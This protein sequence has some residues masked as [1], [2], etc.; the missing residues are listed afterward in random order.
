MLT[1]PAALALL[2]RP[3]RPAL[4]EP[5]GG[6]ALALLHQH[7]PEL[8]AGPPVPDA[9]PQR[10]DQHAAR[11]PQLDARARAGT[12]PRSC[13]ATT[14]RRSG[15][16]SGTTSRTPPRSTACSS[17]S[18]SSGRSPA[19]AISML[20]PEAFQ[21]RPELPQEVATSTPTTAA[22]VEP[23]DGPAAVAFSDG[24]VVGATLDRNGLRPGRWL[25][26]H[27]GWVVLASE[28][29]VFKVTRR[30]RERPR[31]ACSRASSSWSTSRRTAIVPDEE[32]KLDLARRR[33]YG[34]WLRDR[35]VHIEDLPDRSPRVPRV[36]P[37]RARQ[38]AFGWSEED[39]RVILAP[40][41]A[42]RRPSPPARWATTSP[43]PRCRTRGPRSS[44]T[45]S[46]SSPRSRTRPSTRSAS[47]W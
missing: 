19:H 34:E 35:V 20:M 28:T 12:W 47:P 1:A 37:L 8:G 2:P 40:M 13:S 31:A 36:E 9:R 14:W 30:E 44:P 42:R 11:Q 4:R 15:R 7:L 41:A 32:I 46:S 24:R 29:G 26:T 22:L 6:R 38:L 21:G 18:C 43:P 16:S 45:S 10:R 27:D 3:A 39:L 33:P 23:W 25:E 5:P 17:C